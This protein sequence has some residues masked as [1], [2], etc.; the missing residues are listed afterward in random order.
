MRS[1]VHREEPALMTLLEDMWSHV[2]QATTMTQQQPNALSASRVN[3]AHH[4]WVETL[5]Q[6]STVLKELTLTLATLSV[7][8]ANQVTHVQ[9]KPSMVWWLVKMVNS[10]LEETWPAPHVHRTTSAQTGQMQTKSVRSQR[11]KIL[12]DAHLS[13]T[14]IQLIWITTV[15]NAQMVKSARELLIHTRSKIT[16]M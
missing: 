4:L 13:I 9:T 16:L 14:M 3:T 12:L 10:K 15:N 7:F 2:H 1:D 11:D 6:V 5:M 8:H